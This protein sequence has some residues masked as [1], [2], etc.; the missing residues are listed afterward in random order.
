MSK[1]YLG[2]DLGGTTIKFGMVDEAGKVRKQW[3]IPTNIEDGGSHILPDML[4]SIGNYLPKY[5]SDQVMGIGLGTPGTVDQVHGTVNGAFNLNW[6]TEQPLK[7]KIES[8]FKIPFF[9]ENDANVAALGERWVGAGENQNEVV[10]VTLGTGIGGGIIAN[11]KLVHGI[12]GSGGEIGHIVV[13]PDGYPCTCGN[14]GCLETIASATGIARVGESFAGKY[15][16]S[17]LGEAAQKGKLNAKIVFDLAKSGDQ[18][19]IE[20]VDYV[21]YYLAWGLGQVADVLNPQY[22]VIGGGVSASGQFLIDH[23]NKFFPNFVF[24]NIKKTTSLR[25]AELGN[26]AGILGAA[27]LVRESLKEIE[28]GV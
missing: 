10:F 17:L 25:L 14:R 28:E 2:I 15:P 20:A 22:I 9:V 26:D 21:T 12:A 24:D 6:T 7:E 16:E 5:A 8:A 18:A 19:A 4:D 13:K 1:L 27:S 3:N 23:I 11:G